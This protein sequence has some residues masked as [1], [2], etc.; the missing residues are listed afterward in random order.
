MTLDSMGIATA[1]HPTLTT[2]PSP[3]SFSTA[4][5]QTVAWNLC[6]RD[7]INGPSTRATTS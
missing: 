4:S 6:Y 7:A 1:E 2:L 5:T 3:E